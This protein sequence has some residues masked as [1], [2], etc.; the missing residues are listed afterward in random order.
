MLKRKSQ[1]RG[2]LSRLRRDRRG[3]VAIEFALVAVP[4]FFISLGIIEVGIM[5]INS[6]TLYGALEEGARKLRTGEIEAAGNEDAQKALFRNTVCNS[7]FLMSCSDVVFRIR[8]F[9]DY[10]SVVMDLPEFGE[11]GLPDDQFDPGA[12]DQV[13]VAQVYARYH[14]KTPMLGTLFHDDADSR[15]LSYAAIVK[16]EPWD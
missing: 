4:L 5:L 9:S 1:R 6:V 3:A 7:L 2:M 12:P 13:T 14:F 11:D 8:T 16:G 10:G 15:L